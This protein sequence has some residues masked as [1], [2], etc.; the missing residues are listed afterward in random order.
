[1]LIESKT[2]IV[3]DKKKKGKNNNGNKKE[4][5]KKE[6]LGDIVKKGNE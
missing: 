1:M 2:K 3:K 5:I 6:T 4:E